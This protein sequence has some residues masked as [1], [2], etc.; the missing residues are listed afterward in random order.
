MTTL[1]PPVTDDSFAQAVLQSPIPV[2]V[3]FWAD[4]C[5]PCKMLAPV[6]AELA[7]AYAGRLA[8]VKINADENKQT[9][10]E[11]SVRGLPSLL[12]FANGR[13]LA[14]VVGVQSRTRLE[15]FV[16]AHLEA[17]EGAR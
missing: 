12:L 16:D 17:L 5:G 3:D 13:E 8:V 14:R 7:S 10:S 11:H 9:M 1:T 2:L 6:L 4:W 15:V